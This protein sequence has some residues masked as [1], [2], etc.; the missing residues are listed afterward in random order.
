MGGQGPARQ[1]DADDKFATNARLCCHGL[2]V[3]ASALMGRA[4]CGRRHRAGQRPTR[5]CRCAG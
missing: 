5:C 4:A 3:A 2:P 1:Q